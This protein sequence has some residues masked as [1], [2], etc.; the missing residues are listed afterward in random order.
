MCMPRVCV[1]MH[2]RVWVCVCAWA[3]VHTHSSTVV[4]QEILVF[5]GHQVESSESQAKP[6]ILGQLN[7][8]AD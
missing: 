3:C 5:C 8:D 1:C 6:Q 4:L 2:T 7:S